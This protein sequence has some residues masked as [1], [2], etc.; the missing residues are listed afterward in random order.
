L[1]DTLAVLPVARNQ[2]GY[3]NASAASWGGNV[4][5][6]DGVYH[7]IAAQMTRGCGLEK[8]GSNSAIVRSTSNS[9]AG[10]FVFKQQVQE[11][12]GHNPTIRRL[13]RGEGFVIFFIGGTTVQQNCTGNGTLLG[14][15][16]APPPPPLVGGSI[17]AI[18]APTIHGPWSLP[19]A[20][21]FDDVGSNRSLWT[22]GGTNPSPHIEPDGSVTLALQR[23]FRY[24]HKQSPVAC[25]L[26]VHFERLLV[27]AA[28]TSRRNPAAPTRSCSGWR[29][30]PRG[31]GRT[32]C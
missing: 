18:H 12:F 30:R 3:H 2:S 28:L 17:H 11:P 1:C 20:I 8:Y 29:E 32:Q 26:R 14:P 4:V 24:V 6:Q 21:E 15:L 16:A 23:D 5:L 7:L 22:G 31:K 25:D 13:P 10:P 27:V 9:P 19:I